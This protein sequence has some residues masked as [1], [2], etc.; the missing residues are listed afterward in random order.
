MAIAQPPVP[1]PVVKP[2]PPVPRPVTPPLL[3]MARQSDAYK[4]DVHHLDPDENLELRTYMSIGNQIDNIRPDN[5]LLSELDVV[6]LAALTK[7]IES[8]LHAEVRMALDTLATATKSPR[9]YAAI[10]LKACEDLVE[11]LADCAEEQLELL[12]ENTVEVSD[13]IQLSSYEEVARAAKV[14]KMTVRRVPE[15]GSHEHTLDRAVDR[16]TC[17]FTILRNLSFDFDE[18]EV[19]RIRGQPPKRLENDVVL[20]DETVMNLLCLLIRY[21]GTRTMLLR[22]S[23][24]TLELMKDAITLISN[25]AGASTLANKEHAECLLHFLLAFAPSPGPSNRGDQLHFPTHSPELQPYL[26]DAIDA[27]AKLLARDEPNRTHYKAIF[28]A[29]ANSTPPYDLLTKSFGLGICVLP[30]DFF[31]LQSPYH[32]V[33]MERKPLIMQGLMV[34]N[35]LASLAPGS[36]S[37]VARSWLGSSNGFASALMHFIWLLSHET[38]PQN[39]GRDIDFSYMIRLAVATLQKL[40]EKSW[41][42]NGESEELPVGFMPSMDNLAQL[43]RQ[44]TTHMAGEGVVKNLASYKSMTLEM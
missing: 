34:T 19:A 42:P 40:T 23:A 4:P 6:D 39:Q 28:A 33:I 7:S 18:Q 27:L 10:Y 8:G 35:I 20:A 44:L 14:E 17:I 11:A 37:G 32:P 1:E 25:I 22:T 24:S 29:D 30:M 31:P 41:N 36:E 12:A 5:P 21:L 9:P 13:E 3:R 16:L 43:M 38:G 2:E 15:F 26:Y